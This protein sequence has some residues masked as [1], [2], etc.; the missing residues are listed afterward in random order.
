MPGRQVGVTR[1]QED[2][3]VRPL[4]HNSFGKLDPRHAG[5]RLV[6]HHQIN[7]LALIQN[8]ERLSR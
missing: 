8:F 2:R 3:K 7:S 6:R 1:C 4:A 5:H